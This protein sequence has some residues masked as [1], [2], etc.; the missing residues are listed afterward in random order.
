MS[1]CFVI[2]SRLITLN[3]S[4]I[5]VFFIIEKLLINGVNTLSN[6]GTYYTIIRANYSVVRQVNMDSLHTLSCAVWESA[7][8]ICHL[9]TE[10]QSSWS[11]HDH[12]DIFFPH[13]WNYES[14]GDSVSAR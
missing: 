14:S 3:K 1:F 5:K 12:T 6:Q 8:Q 13:K 9:Q 11:C 2:S 7:I 10:P 4:L